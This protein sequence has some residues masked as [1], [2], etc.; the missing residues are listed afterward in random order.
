MKY[1]WYSL[2]REYSVKLLEDELIK[3]KQN[4]IASEYQPLQTWWG[5]FPGPELSYST[6]SIPRHHTYNVTSQS[7]SIETLL[8][9][10]NSEKNKYHLINRRLWSFITIIRHPINRIISHF[11]YEGLQRFFTSYND[12]TKQAPF[13]TQNY[14]VR[15]FSG[16]FPHGL[17]K[18]SRHPWAVSLSS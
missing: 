13:H 11:R 5:M 9:Y 10:Y 12:W 18:R 1:G 17:D 4:I 6:D 8:Q 2:P 7:L 3:M 14:Y 15:M 16:K